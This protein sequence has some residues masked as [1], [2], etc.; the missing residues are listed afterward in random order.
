MAIEVFN[1]YENKY[2][3]DG[4]TFEKL[5]GGLCQ[6]MGLDTHNQGQETYPVA[7]LYYDTPDNTLIRTSLEKP[8]YK[9]KLRLRAYGVPGPDEKVYVEIKKKV[10]GLVNKRRSALRLEDAYDFLASGEPPRPRPYQNRQVLGE[11]AY[12]LQ[13]Y[14]LYPAVYLAYDRLAWFGTAEPDLR[15]SFDRNI[16]TR[17][18]DLALEAGDYGSPLLPDG[19]WLMEI[20]AARSIPLWL[21][22]LLSDY[23]IYPTS[24]SKYGTEYQK[25]L[26]AAKAPQL[27][28]HFQPQKAARPRKAAAANA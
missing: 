7:S 9:E 1:R 28:Y 21:C 22:R 11:I 27:V 17:R 4:D 13:T 5:Q 14:D 25:T 19:C 20:K 8:R 24:F 18:Y 15:V 6:S 2:L 26:E 23:E 12:L 3:L 16:R 10:A